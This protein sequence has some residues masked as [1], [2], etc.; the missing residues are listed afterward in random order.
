MLFLE[1]SSL[2]QS[3][4]NSGV[5]ISLEVTLTGACQHLVCADDNNLLGF[6]MFPDCSFGVFMILSTYPLSLESF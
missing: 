3:L 1:Y 6:K 4:H 2:F 5:W